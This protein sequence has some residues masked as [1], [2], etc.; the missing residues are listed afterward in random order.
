MQCEAKKGF[1]GYRSDSVGSETGCEPKK[2]SPENS[3][4]IW[5]TLFIFFAEDAE[6]TALLGAGRASEF[7]GFLSGLCAAGLLCDAD[8]YGQSKSPKTPG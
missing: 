3:Q 2:G 4:G 1:P 8:W 7:L 6:F 5:I